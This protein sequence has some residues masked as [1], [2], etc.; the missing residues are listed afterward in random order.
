[1]RDPGTYLTA[2]WDFLGEG[3]NGTADVWT[4]KAGGG[5]PQHVWSR[6]DLDG[7]SGVCFGDFAVLAGRWQD[8]CWPSPDCGG[9]DIDF[10]GVVD[11]ADLAV[12]CDA[13]LAVFGY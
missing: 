1:M 5:Y 11:G 8:S 9:A 6:L 7:R 4:M 12:L 13:W 3:G 2:G 10:S